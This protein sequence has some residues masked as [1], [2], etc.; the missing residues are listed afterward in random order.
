M[1][2]LASRF[3]SN[4][5]FEYA[6]MMPPVCDVEHDDRAPLPAERVGREPAAPAACIVST[7]LPRVS[8]P[9]KKSLMSSIGDVEVAP[10]ELVVVLGLDAGV[11][12]VDRLVADDVGEQLAVSG[13]YTRWIC[14][15]SSSVGTDWARIVPSAR[16]DRAA[17]RE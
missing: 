4:V 6:A 7:T 15:S 14:S 5:G 1:S 2:W 17:R 11:A 13:G 16:Q 12:E 3:G 9:L 10:D 8:L